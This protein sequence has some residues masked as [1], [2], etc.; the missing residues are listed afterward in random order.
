MVV[1]EKCNEPL[2]LSYLPTPAYIWNHTIDLLLR[3]AGRIGI[4]IQSIHKVLYNIHMHPRRIVIIFYNTIYNLYWSR[5]NFTLYHFTKSPISAFSIF[6][7]FSLQASTS[8][9]MKLDWDF[10]FT[11]PRKLL[12][13]NIQLI[14][15][16]EGEGVVT[17]FK[18]NS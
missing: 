3:E 13:C 10:I 16:A 2:F 18:I 5:F 7:F 15:Y 9:I 8:T 1:Y 12:P 17:D 6:F 4:Y 14:N 11:T